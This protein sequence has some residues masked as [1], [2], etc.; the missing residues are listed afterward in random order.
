MDKCKFVETRRMDWHK[1]RHVCIR[2]DWCTGMTNDQYGRMLDMA[3]NFENV[4]QTELAQ[5]A[6]QISAGSSP[7]LAARCDCTQDE[8]VCHI[9]F[10]L[11]AEC[12]VST[13]G[14]AE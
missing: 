13:F 12:C 7:D 4:T 1:V 10:V 11:T 2:E 5:I 8:Y 9:M 14:I 3:D 6:E